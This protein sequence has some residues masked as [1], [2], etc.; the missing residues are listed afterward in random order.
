[1]KYKLTEKS[2]RNEQGIK[3]YRIESLI[4]Q[5]YA[6]KGELGGWV[7]SEK[8][9]S[10]EG[11]AW[12]S[13]DAEAFNNAVVRENARLMDNAKMYDNAR[14][15]GDA[16]I[17][18]NARITED[19][20]V[21]GEGLVQGYEVIRG[22]N[23]VTHPG[24]KLAIEKYIDPSK[25]DKIIAYKTQGALVINQY[26]YPQF[27]GTIDEWKQHILTND[28]VQDEQRQVLMAAYIFIKEM[29]S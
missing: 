21:C 17:T 23:K 11:A 16:M 6:K 29:L 4:D 27:K 20:E 24:T 3:L 28:K 25:M 12:I 22:K 9:L 2:K 15:Y 1:M 7:E 13:E 26:I 5:F 14:A 8:N 18:D 10:Q 19:A